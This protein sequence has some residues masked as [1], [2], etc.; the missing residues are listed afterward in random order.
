MVSLETES[1][2]TLFFDLLPIEVGT[3]GGFKTRLQ[4]YT[5]PGQVF[6]NTTR[7]LVLKGVDGLVFVADSQRPMREANIESFES[8]TENLREL[9]IE[10][11]DLPLVLQYN[12]RDLKNILSIE[13]LAADLNPDGKYSHFESEAINGPGV[14]ETLKEITKLT[15]KK[16]R[17]RM[18]APHAAPAGPR[19]P[20]AEVHAAKPPPAKPPSVSAAAL[21][22][23]AAEGVGSDPEIGER[24]VPSEAPPPEATSV[25]E[26]SEDSPFAEDQS[27]GVHAEA[28]PEIEMDEEEPFE[29]VDADS[30]FAGDEPTSH[31]V[32]EV[33]APDDLAMV[34]EAEE[35]VEVIEDEEPASLEFVPGEPEVEVEFDQTNGEAVEE[36]PPPLKRVQV[37]NQMDILAELEGLRKQ[38]TMGSFGRRIEESRQDLDIDALLAGSEDTRELQRKV[39]Q[40]LNSDVFQ[41]M[42]GIQLAIRIE[43]ADGETLHTLDPVSLRVEKAERLKKLSLRFTVD[44]ENHQ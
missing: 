43:D 19:M 17:N 32:A 39:E 21:A 29:A 27:A 23:A 20:S 41:H 9:G 24:P 37:S 25:G 26:A 40:A 31:A 3:I 10:P 18:V 42:N 16:L 13:E 38:A 8:L 11:D 34:S 44:L 12:K 22:R 7:K 28:V 33:E 1:D 35:D 36:E 2:R 5:V 30:P 6:Y 14:F 4:L 15:L